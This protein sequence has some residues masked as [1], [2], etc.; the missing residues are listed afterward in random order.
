MAPPAGPEAGVSGDVR[1]EFQDEEPFW[2]HSQV[3]MLGSPVFRNM[4]DGRMQEGQTKQIAAKGLCRR[5]DFAEFYTFLNPSTAHD[6]KTTDAH[7][8]AVLHLADYYQV[9]WLKTRCV[10][11]LERMPVGAPLAVLG[12]KFGLDGVYKRCVDTFG[13]ATEQLLAKE[14]WV[15]GLNELWELSEKDVVQ[16]VLTRIYKSVADMKRR[17]ENTLRQI[18]QVSN[19]VY[20]RTPRKDRCDEINRNE[21]SGL[22]TVL[23]TS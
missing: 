18:D 5:Q 15:A 12:K 8:A 11:H 7:A 19:S 17:V 22:K 2:A 1:M 20:S 3:L 14:T 23:Q 9:A 21:I 16:D 10:R 4:L 13:L 6:A